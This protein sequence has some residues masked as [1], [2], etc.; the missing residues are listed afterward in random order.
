MPKQ[1]TREE[2]WKLYEK[3]PEELKKAF[4]SDEITAEIENIG[5]RYKIEERKVAAIADQ[6]G[7][8]FLGLLPPD[9]FQEVLI[10][11][12]NLDGETAKKVAREINRYVFFPVKANLE[13]LYGK[14]LISVAKPSKITPPLGEKPKTEEREDVYREPL[15]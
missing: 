4:F 9:E 7:Y 14:E 15:K 8:V 3:L 11:G 6:I 10:K 2:L 12:I 5:R 13:E 1:Y